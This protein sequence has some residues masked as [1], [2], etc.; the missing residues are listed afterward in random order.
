MH[1]GADVALDAGA[2]DASVQIQSDT[3]GRGVDCALDC[4]AKDDTIN[5]AIRAARNGGRVVL[6][7]I[8]AAPMVPFEVSPMRRKELAIF[9]VRRSNHESEEALALLVERTGLVRSPHHAHASAGPHRRGFRTDRKA[10]GRC[11]QDD[12]L[13]I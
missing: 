13:S 6:T 5:Q 10:R 4:A 9:N 2:G 11:G 8:H 12:H 7:G 3:R 1:L